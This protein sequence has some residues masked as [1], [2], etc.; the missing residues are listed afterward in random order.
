MNWFR[1]LTG[2]EE[3]DPETVTR[4]IRCEGTRLFSAANGREFEAGRLRCPSLAELRVATGGMRGQLRFSE[5][6]ADARA[7]HRAPHNAGAVFQVASQF[8]LL[9][10]VGP[11]VTP[12]MGIAGYAFDHTQG[13]ACAMACGAGTIY[14]NYFVPLA[15]RAGQS[16][17][18]QINCLADLG[19]A[20]GNG[21][22]ALWEMQNGYCLPSRF[23]LGAVADRLGAAAVEEWDRLRGLLRVGV[24]EDTEVT[25]EGAGHFVTQVYC[26]AMPVA[27]SGLRAD[28][29]EPLARLVLE[30]AYEAVLRVGALRGGPVFLTALGGGAFG[31]RQEWIA[32]AM[33]RALEVMAGYDLDVVL[34]SY[35][36]RS[37]L[38]AEVGMR[39]GVP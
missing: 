4:L 18:R 35:G 3:D 30:A 15:G 34:V 16:W 23:G 10:M 31:N 25:D 21:A 1:N 26:S 29:W 24:Q 28:A 5:V 37:A 27:Y 6:V 20:L 33:V 9:E 32:D 2:F 12:E 36:E 38:A 19:A 14:R 22:G 39:A 13:P 7:L 8:N 11:S 17:D